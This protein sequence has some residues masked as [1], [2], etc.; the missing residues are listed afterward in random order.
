MSAE[1][2]VMPG[3]LQPGFIDRVTDFTTA[4]QFD[5]LTR[6]LEQQG[7]VSWLGRQA[8]EGTDSWDT[9]ASITDGLVSAEVLAVDQETHS[10]KLSLGFNSRESGETFARF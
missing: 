9:L 7:L 6:N 1:Q 8:V 2:P 3:E 5:K 4:K 10:T